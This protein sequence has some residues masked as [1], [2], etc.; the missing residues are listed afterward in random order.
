MSMSTWQRLLSWAPLCATLLAGCSTVPPAGQ[1]VVAQPAEPAASAPAAAASAPAA[2]AVASTADA[3]AIEAA[4]NAP[5][6]AD[7]PRPVDPLRPE[8][9]VDLNDIAAQADLW[10]RVRRGF[11]MPELD[12]DLVRTAETWYATR[13]DYV[14]R[15]TERG[16][17]YLFHIVEE[18][19][20]RGMP[21]ELALLPLS[22]IHI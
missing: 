10:A 9:V 21:T 12:T 20:R 4:V 17:R 18:V 8:S 1:A 15:M 11:A 6:E 2:D 3:A 16:S 13:P 5:V 19:E 14:Q 22:L 7:A